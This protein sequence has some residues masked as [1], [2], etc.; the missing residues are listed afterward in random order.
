M[1]LCFCPASALHSSMYNEKSSNLRTAGFWRILCNDVI[2]FKT[3]K[4]FRRGH[5]CRSASNWKRGFGTRRVYYS[6]EDIFSLLFSW[7]GYFLATS[8]HHVTD[9]GTRIRVYVFISNW[10]WR[11][12]TTRC[13][14]KFIIIENFYSWGHVLITLL[15]LPG[16]VKVLVV[17]MTRSKT[18]GV[19]YL[20]M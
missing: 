1:R 16:I 5:W 6:R 20:G 13:I 7:W 11:I 19:P 18:Y 4:T 14:G 17:M 15:C 3:K 8:V 10:T 9:A 12:S 2:V